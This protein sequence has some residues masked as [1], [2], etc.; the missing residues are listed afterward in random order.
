MKYIRVKCMPIYAM[1]TSDE[2]LAMPERSRYNA[3]IIWAHTMNSFLPLDDRLESMLNIKDVDF[4]AMKDFVDI[5]EEPEMRRLV[6][7]AKKARKRVHKVD[8][9]ESCYPFLQFWSDYRKPLDRAKARMC[10][11]QLGEDARQLIKAHLGGYV[12]NTPD[13]RYRKS[14]WRYIVNRTWKDGPDKAAA[15]SVPIELPDI[16]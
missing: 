16:S 11:G 5:L 1:V 12:R 3:M 8:D 10:Y 6:D 14:P 15:Y 13:P 7:E 9:S 4:E 2:F